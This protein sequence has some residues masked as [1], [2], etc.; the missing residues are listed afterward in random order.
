MEKGFEL[1]IGSVDK[2][3]AK[4]GKPYYKI[5]GMGDGSI[6]NLL[7]FSETLGEYA[8]EHK[9]EK[10]QAVTF[11]PPDKDYIS[12]QQIQGVDTSHEQQQRKSGGGGGR[13]Y[14]GGYNNAKPVDKDKM[15]TFVLSY[16][17]DLVCAE[18]A[19]GHVEESVARTVSYTQELLR[20]VD[21]HKGSS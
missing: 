20:F 13:Q 6:Q 16:A 7:C 2:K 5:V 8:I 17:K 11:A 21:E 12:L 15:L 19:Q 4:S 3:M 18:I 9:N 1:T 10:V 14:S